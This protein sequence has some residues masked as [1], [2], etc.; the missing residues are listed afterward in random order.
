MTETREPN[1]LEKAFSSVGDFFKQAGGDIGRTLDN[2]GKALSPDQKNKSS[3]AGAADFGMAEV[4]HAP[5][6]AVNEEAEKERERRVAEGLDADKSAQLERRKSI[7]AADLAME[8]ERKR[9]LDEAAAADAAAG[10]V[11]AERRKSIQAAD[12][13][14]ELE[15]QRRLDEAAAAAAGADA[16]GLER[17]KSQAA[18]D[19]A[20]EAERARRVEERAAEAGREQRA[21]HANQQAAIQ[22]M[23]AEREVSRA[24]PIG[25]LMASDGF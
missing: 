5:V 25:I 18:V 7:Q 17:R 11:S 3:G 21:R 14:M 13:A 1:P 23:E 8:L 16:A 6:S 15:R 10:G 22:A 20:M 2:V 24:R 4:E 19:E 12:S 9:R